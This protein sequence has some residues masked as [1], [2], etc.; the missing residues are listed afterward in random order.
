MRKKGCAIQR[1]KSGHEDVNDQAK[2][3]ARRCGEKRRVVVKM[4][5][6]EFEGF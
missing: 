3:S 6:T 5:T 1:E 2:A 4:S